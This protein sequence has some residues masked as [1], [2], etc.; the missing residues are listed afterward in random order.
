MN[1]GH[2]ILIGKWCHCRINTYT[3][4]KQIVITLCKNKSC[5]LFSLV[6]IWDVHFLSNVIIIKTKVYFPQ[7]DVT[8]A[9]F[10]FLTHKDF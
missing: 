2:A 3:Y 1:T 10:G 5:Y 8:L 6:S 9:D 4:Q 7:A